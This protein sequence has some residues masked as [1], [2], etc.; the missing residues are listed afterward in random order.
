MKCE[1]DCYYKVG[2]KCKNAEW[3]AQGIPSNEPKECTD[4]EFIRRLQNGN[5]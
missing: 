2:S 3:A 1:K 5:V 4:D